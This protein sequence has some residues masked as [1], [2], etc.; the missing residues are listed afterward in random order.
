LKQDCYTKAAEDI[1]VEGRK[2]GWRVAGIN[3]NEMASSVERKV[4][5]WYVIFYNMVIPVKY[6]VDDTIVSK[7]KYSTTDVS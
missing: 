7:K 3:K 1:Y 4:V 5:A 6:V 2:G